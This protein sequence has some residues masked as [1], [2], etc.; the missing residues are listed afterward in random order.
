MF[1]KNESV[2][3]VLVNAKG[4][5]DKLGIKLNAV[6]KRGLDANE[7]VVDLARFEREMADI[8]AKRSYSEGQR[9]DENDLI[10][11]TNEVG[12]FL[13]SMCTQLESK[14][15][16]VKDYNPIEPLI[17][18]TDYLYA[19]AMQTLGCPDIPATFGPAVQAQIGK[20]ATSIRSHLMLDH[21]PTYQ[22]RFYYNQRGM[23]AD[24]VRDEVSQIMDAA[25]DGKQTAP[26]LQSLVA[27]YQALRRRQNDHGFFWRLFHRG[28][29]AARTELISDMEVALKGV[30][31]DKIDL[32]HSS[33][34]FLA[35][36]MV[37]KNTA[38]DIEAVF[39]NGDFAERVG[40]DASI[41]ENLDEKQNEN[42]LESTQAL[43]DSLKNALEPKE[44][45]E[46]K[47]PEINEIGA[48][49]RENVI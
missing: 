26:Q 7:K 6:V 10:K 47:Q 5:F 37:A 9:I 15:S 39:A 27:Q 45:N 22:D 23:D 21:A 46:V 38:Q 14:G 44:N 35:E 42:N 29:N 28:E 40:V 36:G 11:I 13:D 31:G 16:G 24:E 2:N 8:A 30:L 4:K 12:F 33:P 19:V 48:P 43:R 1:I 3:D 18:A 49:S 25:K 20:S 34:L 32:M 17:C 41:I